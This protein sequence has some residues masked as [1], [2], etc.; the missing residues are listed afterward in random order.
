MLIEYFS[1]LR[2]WTT[3][4]FDFDQYSCIA[5][6]PVLADVA[7]LKYTVGWKFDVVWGYN[8]HQSGPERPT[9]RKY[10]AHSVDF[11]KDV[12]S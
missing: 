3:S 8:E 2:S 1:A 6:I 4:L 7:D 5:G 11:K 10:S 9:M 12:N